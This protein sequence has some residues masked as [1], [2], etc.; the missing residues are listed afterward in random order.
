MTEVVQHTS[1][2]GD[3][4]DEP[5]IREVIGVEPALRLRGLTRGAVLSATL[6]FMR[7][8]V[9]SWRLGEP[10]DWNLWK[11]MHRIGVR[12]GFVDTITYRY[13]WYPAPKS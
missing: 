2:P 13:H 4:A 1:T 5:T 11:R 9:N 8:D 10:N 12:I 6:A 7:Y 3:G